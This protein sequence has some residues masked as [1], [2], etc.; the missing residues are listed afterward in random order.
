MFVS[1]V[2]IPISHS[3]SKKTPN[4]MSTIGKKEKKYVQEELSS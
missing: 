3:L 4:V 2:R 1:R